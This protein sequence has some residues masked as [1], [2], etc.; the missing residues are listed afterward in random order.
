VDIEY[1][2]LSLVRLGLLFFSFFALSRCVLMI[3]IA[4]KENNHKKMRRGI[5][6]LWGGVLAGCVFLK[7]FSGCGL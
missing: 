6:L 1:I 7:M 2:I 3:K 4:W 5:S